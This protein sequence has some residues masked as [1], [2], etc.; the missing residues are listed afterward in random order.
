[1]RTIVDLTSD[2]I[3]RLERIATREHISRTEAVRRAIEVASPKEDVRQSITEIRR[4][5]FGLWKKHKRDAVKC[6]DALRD[7]WER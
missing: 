7:E 2:Q 1:V 4:Q 3:T 6:I 5:A